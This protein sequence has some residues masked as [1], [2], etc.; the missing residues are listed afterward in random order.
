[1]STIEEQL[2]DANRFGQVCSANNAG[3][4]K[5]IADLAA[6]LEQCAGHI[7]A[8]VEAVDG[9]GILDEEEEAE[10]REFVAEIRALAALHKE[11]A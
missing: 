11:P 8:A 3:L 6:K 10:E 2:Q 9:E 1:M 4:R 5:T 7:E